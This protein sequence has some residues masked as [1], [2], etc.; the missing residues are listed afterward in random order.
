[1]AHALE[2]R[3]PLMDHPLVKWLATLASS[4][5]V[6]ERRSKYLLKRPWNLICRTSSCT[7]EDGFRGSLGR[8]FRDP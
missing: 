2:V 5:K 7:A 3:E 1:M 6:K 8:W 4:L